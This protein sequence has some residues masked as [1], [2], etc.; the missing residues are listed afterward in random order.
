VA[1]IG[2]VVD[3]RSQGSVK[4]P[5]RSRR[6][7]ALR[8]GFYGVRGSCPCSSDQYRRYGGNTPCVT[9]DIGDG[10]PIILDLG[11]GLR[12]LG[13]ELDSSPAAQ[14]GLELVAFLSHLHWDHII[15]LPFFTTAHNP[16]T[17][18][19]IYG[20]PQAEGSL[21]DTFER[22]LHPPFFPIDVEGIEGRVRLKE[23][24]DEVVSVGAANVVVRQVP[25]VG[26]TL[27][28]RVEAAGASVAF[29]SDHQQPDDPLQVDERV[30][31]L[32]D[33]AD[34]LIHDA[35]YTESEFEKK[36]TWG[37]STI[38]YAV[39]VAREAGVKNLALFHHDPLHAD[40]DVDR[41]LAQACTLKEACYLDEVVAASE[42]LVLEVA[43][44]ARSPVAHAAMNGRGAK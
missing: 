35:Q 32:C 33:G 26:T 30:L 4:A 19:D 2:H 3:H 22:V 36:S 28:F 14:N 10:P 25:H 16:K 23:C 38:A 27:G 5:S 29:V 11:T 1:E 15:G 12:V 9:V 18:L 39:H 7:I 17:T 34:L 42:G 8:V 20:P 31:E 41:L 40:D 21:H 13:L 24:L 37:H 43:G 44:G 6:G